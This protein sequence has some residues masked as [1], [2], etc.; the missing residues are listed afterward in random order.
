MVKNDQ[1]LFDQE[2]K[3]TLFSAINIQK[4]SSFSINLL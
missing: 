2:P 1:T 3:T 4:R